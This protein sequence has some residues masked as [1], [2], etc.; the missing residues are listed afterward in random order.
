M[1]AIISAESP[2]K[3]DLFI[4]I[5]LGF[6]DTGALPLGVFPSTDFVMLVGVV[7]TLIPVF[8][9]AFNEALLSIAAAMIEASAESIDELTPLLPQ[10]SLIILEI[11]SYCS[12]TSDFS[13][14]L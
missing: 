6:L 10:V 13:Y 3:I 1:L 8:L 9:D 11:P 12:I 7:F 4:D 5:A 2:L 14:S